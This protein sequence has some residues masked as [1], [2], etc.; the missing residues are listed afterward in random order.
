MYLEACTLRVKSRG[1]DWSAVVLQLV[2][3]PYIKYVYATH[4]RDFV[5]R[6]NKPSERER[7]RPNY[8]TWRISESTLLCKQSF[9]IENCSNRVISA[10]FLQ[11][12]SLPCSCSLSPY[13]VRQRRVYLILKI[14]NGSK[15]KEGK[16]KY[17]K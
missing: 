13:T 16:S 4:S 6:V 12:Y 3:E 10:G 11:A 7:E 8:E 2:D 1:D 9:Q 14:E 15:S 5:L 17:K